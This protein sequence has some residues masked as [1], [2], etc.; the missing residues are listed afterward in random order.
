MVPLSSRAALV[1]VFV[2]VV[3][4]FGCGRAPAQR[5]PPREAGVPVAP[6]DT[7]ATF[8]ALTPGANEASL[9]PPRV[10]ARLRLAP[11]VAHDRL[12]ALPAG[13]ALRVA[14]RRAT[15][16]SSRSATSPS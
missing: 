9:Y 6:G 3:G 7:L 1:L 10:T 5:E 16:S 8:D 4:P 12:V 2:F 11:A 13:L 14:W 15:T